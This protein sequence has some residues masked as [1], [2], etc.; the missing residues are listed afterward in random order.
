MHRPR[1]QPSNRLVT[2]KYFMAKKYDVIVIGGG[3]NGLVNAAYLAKAGKK[4]LVLEKRHVLGGAAV[5]EEIIP[6]FKFSVFSYVVSLSAP[7]NHSRSRSAAPRPGN[8]SPRR[9]VH[10]D[11]QRRLPLAPERS[12]QNAPRTRAPLETRRR[13]LRR[14]RQVHGRD[15]PLRETDPGHDPSGPNVPRSARPEKTS[16][17]RQTLPNS[18]RRGQIQPRAAHDYERRR[19][20]RPVVRDGRAESHHVRFRNHRH[21]SWHSFA[22]HRLR[23]AAPLH[24]RN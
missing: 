7:G 23:P 21:F 4:V 17:P 12:R 16:I 24:G 6:G 14:I 11:A 8:S 22:G 1:V 13:S 5:T 10:A 9:H 20:S 3:H 2:Q 15:V 18:R 19:F